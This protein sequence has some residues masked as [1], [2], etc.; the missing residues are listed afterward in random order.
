MTR[1]INLILLVMGCIASSLAFEAKTQNTLKTMT[2]IQKDEP[3]KG[4][5]IAN[6]IVNDSVTF[7]KYR[8]ATVGLAQKHQGKMIMRDINSKTVEGVD[9]K[10]IMAIIE[11]PT[12]EDAEGYYNS[13]E[14]T[15]ARNFGTASAERLIILAKGIPQAVRVSSGQPKG[16]LV[17]NFTIHNQDTFKKYIETG[18]TVVEK[19]NGK[20]IVYDVN[21]KV[22][23]GNGK[24]I[25]A[26]M[27]FPSLNDLERFYNSPEYVAARKFRIA[28]TE[29]SVVLGEGMTEKRGKK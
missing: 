11:F 1:K 16:Y 7:Q 27:E 22:V 17:A 21:A 2:K 12:F 18:G 8:D 19:F 5:L 25:I 9:P 28:A 10:Q 23:E 15:K 14:Y 6:F 20:A 24:Q 3:P 4:Y 13:P 29:G 26:V